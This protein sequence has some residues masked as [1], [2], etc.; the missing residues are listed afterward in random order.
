V[1][2]RLEG[3][4]RQCCSATCTVLQCLVLRLRFVS[5]WLQAE[6][7]RRAAEEKQKAEDEESAESQ[8]LLCISA[9]PAGGGCALCC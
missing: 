9:M 2:L 3:I 7:M 8:M 1:L 4:C 5:F 6:E